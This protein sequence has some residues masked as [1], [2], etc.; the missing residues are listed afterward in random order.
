MAG[1]LSWVQGNWSAAVGAAGI[2]GSLLFTAAYFQAD[3]KNRLV[4]NL[5]AIEERH[6]AFWSEAQKR[7]DLRRIFFRQT[8][9]LTLPLTSEEDLFMRRM[10]G[11]F[12]TGWRIEQVL[13]RGEMKLLAKDVAETFSLPLPRA[14]WEKTKEFRN[15]R[16]VLFVE[17]ALTSIR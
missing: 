11:F 14:V 10:I 7:K 15:R 6:R 1:L 3:S 17:R 4:A 16:F 2:I 8:T 5:M 9:G 12:E 13:K